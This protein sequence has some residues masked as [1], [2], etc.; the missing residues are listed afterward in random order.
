LGICAV[1]ESKKDRAQCQQMRWTDDCSSG[2]SSETRTSCLK[3]EKM[4]HNR[5]VNIVEEKNE[6]FFI[7]HLDDIPDDEYELI[8]YDAEEY[9]EIK[10]MYQ[11]TI[12]MMETG[13]PIEPEEEHTSRGLEYRTQEGA[14]AR[15]ENK[16]D[17][18]NAVLDEQDRQWQDDSDDFE[19]ISSLYVEHSKKCL[20]AA[21]ERGM[22]DEREA[23][24]IF[25]SLDIPEP[26]PAL[27][28]KKAKKKKKS[29]RKGKRKSKTERDADKIGDK[30]NKVKETLR[31]SSGSRRSEVLDDIK[32]LERGQ[33][34]KRTGPRRLASL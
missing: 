17:A 9:A 3:K 28:E 11:V 32:R 18:C 14:W 13:E 19:L 6:I 30:V 10:Q 29:D 2:C 26:A 33:R 1:L 15:H 34:E 4:P 24:E 7:T 16:R 5:T 25:K 31:E 12:I 22:N 8:W 23:V 20:E 21:A 27:P